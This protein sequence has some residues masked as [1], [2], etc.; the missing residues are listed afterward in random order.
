MV[1]IFIDRKPIPLLQPVKDFISLEVEVSPIP[2]LLPRE[3]IIPIANWVYDLSQ[4][5]NSIMYNGT[6]LEADQVNKPTPRT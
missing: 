3:L 2:V 6:I 5:A 1:Q 4:R